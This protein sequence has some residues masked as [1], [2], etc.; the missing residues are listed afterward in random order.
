MVCSNGGTNRVMEKGSF[1]LI[2]DVWY[3]PDSL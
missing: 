1:G 2:D 3:N